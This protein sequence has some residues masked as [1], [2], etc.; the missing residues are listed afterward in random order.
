MGRPGAKIPG[1]LTGHGNTAARRDPD[2]RS[3]APTVEISDD[4][5]ESTLNA[6]LIFF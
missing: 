5:G 2:L 6:L 1:I 4:F 3:R